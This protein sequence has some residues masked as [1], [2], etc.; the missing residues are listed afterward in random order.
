MTPSCRVEAKWKQDRQCTYNVTLWGVR[1]TIM[2]W[3]HN[4]A[5]CLCLVVV[6]FVDEL[7][8]NLG[9]SKYSLSYNNA[10]VVNLCHQQQC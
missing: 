7:H 9:Y 2:Q 5:F 1:V 8:V 4:T 6:V 3:K 10:F